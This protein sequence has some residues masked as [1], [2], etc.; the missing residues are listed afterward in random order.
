MNAGNNPLPYK[1]GSRVRLRP[2]FDQVYPMSFAGAEALIEKFTIDPERFERILVKWDRNHYRYNNE[3]DMWTYA[4][5]FEVIAPPDIVEEPIPDDEPIVVGGQE[6][7]DPELLRRLLQ[8]AGVAPPEQVEEIDNYA[9]LLQKTIEILTTGAAFMVVTVAPT[10]DDDGTL[11]PYFFGAQIDPEAGR[12]AEIAFV[13]IASEVMK[14][15]A[16]QREQ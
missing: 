13:T 4:S 6:V 8:G 2:G 1:A 14:K 3:K 10:P 15:L 12:A 9:N 5:H 7:A 16:N 11:A